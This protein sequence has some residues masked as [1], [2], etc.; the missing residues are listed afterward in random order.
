MIDFEMVE[1][2]EESGIDYLS[3]DQPTLSVWAVSGWDTKQNRYNIL[4]YATETKAEAYAKAQ[5]NYPTLD[6]ERVTF[7]AHY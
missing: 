6:I 7:V 1:K 3:D 2:M 5:H 4:N